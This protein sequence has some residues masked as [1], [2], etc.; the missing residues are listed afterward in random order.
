MSIFNFVNNSAS[1]INNGST[2]H[3]F[4]TRT[5]FWFATGGAGF[6]LSQSL[7]AKMMPYVGYDANALSCPVFS[8]WKIV[9]V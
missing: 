3:S 4:Q 9:L 2:I 5:S 8:L 7:A 6:C 1:I